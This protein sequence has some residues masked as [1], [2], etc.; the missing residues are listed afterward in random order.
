MGEADGTD[1]VYTCERC[2]K[3]RPAGWTCACGGEGQGGRAEL[4]GWDPAT[5]SGSR[6]RLRLVQ[7]PAPPDPSE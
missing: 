4:P 2:G 7:R 3:V 6:P 5:T 1:E